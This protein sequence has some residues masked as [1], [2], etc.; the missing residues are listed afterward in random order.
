MS[1]PAAPCTGGLAAYGLAW[2]GDAW[3]LM[4]LATYVLQVGGWKGCKGG[5]HGHL[6][7]FCSSWLAVLLPARGR[8]RTRLWA[9]GSH[10]SCS[11]V[12]SPYIQVV[13][14]AFHLGR[15]PGA[16]QVVP[17]VAAAQ[18]VLLLFRLQVRQDEDRGGA[19][20]RAFVRARL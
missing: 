5:G 3:R 10:A 13:L 8:T 9:L 14:A 11:C 1:C 19:A 15:L 12:P 4:G 16:E 17:V 6:A 20:C 7:P 18:C 2:L